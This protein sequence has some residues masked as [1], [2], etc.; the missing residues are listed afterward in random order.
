MVF[1]CVCVC[2]CL[3][4]W[5]AFPKLQWR[6][7]EGHVYIAPGPRRGRG[8]DVDLGGFFLCCLLDVD[9]SDSQISWIQRPATSTYQHW[10]YRDRKV[11]ARTDRRWQSVASTPNRRPESKKR[12]PANLGATTAS[13]PPGHKTSCYATAYSYDVTDMQRLLLEYI[14]EGINY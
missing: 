8:P 11:I 4:C 2:V 10:N 3:Y 14:Q 5:H 1:V 6:K 7:L 13:P 12:S 9:N